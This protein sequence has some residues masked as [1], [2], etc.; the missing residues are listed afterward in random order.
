[1][2]V[3]KSLQIILRLIISLVIIGLIGCSK[4]SNS[5]NADKE[6]D[7]TPV[8]GGELNV[9]IGSEPDSLDWMYISA[10]ATRDI[11]WNMFET[12]FALDQD[13]GAKP[14]IAKDYKL[15]DDEKTYTIQ[16]RKGVKFHNGATVT[17]DDV[18][19][20]IERWEKVSS[21]GKITG[22]YIK[23]VKAI[24]AY[25]VEIKL[26]E[27]YH[28]FVSD[29]TAPKSALIVIPE[30]IANEA[31]DKPLKQNQLIGTGPYQFEKWDKGNEIVLTR[32]DDYTA[33]EETDWN[34]LTGEKVAYL[35]K[36]NFQIVKDPQVMVNGLKTGIYDYVESIPADLFDVIDANA[37]LDPVT[38]MN[39]YN[40][41]SMDKT[42]A[43]F[44]D[45][46][47]R[48]ALQ[49]ALDKKSIAQAA[50]GNEQFYSFDG[51]LFDPE[52]GELYSDKGIDNYLAY[53]KQ[54]AK[55]LLNES[56]YNGKTLTILYSNDTAE[57]EKIAQIA[58]QQ[59]EEIGF[60]VKL[61][62]YEW[63]TYLEKWMDPSNWDLVVIGW[64]TRFSP[65]ELGMLELNAARSGW[66]TSERWEEL[67]NQWGTAKSTE[68]KQEILGEMN[69]TIYDELPFI[70]I[71]NVKR[72]DAKSNKVRHLENW[73]G[74]RFWN[75]WKQM[76]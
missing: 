73:V 11:A 27:I 67:I 18:V 62:P 26:K 57:Y 52:Q 60:K 42:E 3:Y 30:E 66:Y 69:Q 1:M 49:Y 33:R 36:L 71:S 64:S 47:A 70:K 12:L 55:E 5:Q 35:D 39:G 2:K 32:F 28:A 51:A 25:T 22:K 19:A 53:D 68:E 76:E 34:G 6:T 63:A 58:K 17:A 21:V 13:F 31:D 45:I 50:Y 20:S 75:T 14:M 46:K 56:N 15:S 65:S 4:D 41:I 44:D 72:F 10:T 40:I 48:Q 61:E 43:P 74:P 38:Y 8:K 29:M 37:E 54:K 9:A 23:R 7:G 16:L 24:D 59:M